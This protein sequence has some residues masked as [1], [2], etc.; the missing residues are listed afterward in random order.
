MPFPSLNASSYP[1]GERGPPEAALK[2]V[3]INVT[4]PMDQELFQDDNLGAT[5][6]TTKNLF[7]FGFGMFISKQ[8]VDFFIYGNKC[9]DP[10][11]QGTF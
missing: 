4:M 8:M 10:Y 6:I 3:V 9:P 2:R 1:K 7:K 11:E 5:S